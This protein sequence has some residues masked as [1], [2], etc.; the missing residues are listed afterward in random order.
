MTCVAPCGYQFC[1]LCLEHWELPGHSSKLPCHKFE[2]ERGKI[3]SLLINARTE[4]RNYL[5][6]QN[7]WA[8]NNQS[9]E[10]ALSKMSRARNELLLVLCKV[11]A[12]TE[13][14]LHALLCVLN[15]WEQIAECRRVLKWSYAYE[16]FMDADDEVK[17]T[18]FKYLQ[19]EGESA[20]KRLHHCA[21]K[22]MEK[23]VEADGPCEDFGK[24]LDKAYA[25]DWCYKDI[26]SESGESS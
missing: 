24:F 6:Y 4:L 20:L 25:A 8:S 11:L 7:G 2:M 19:A 16:Y 12:E 3:S 21:E 17:K 22:E 18:F 15:A 13:Y 14:V 10:I 23:Y 9:R 1:W 5:H 26:L